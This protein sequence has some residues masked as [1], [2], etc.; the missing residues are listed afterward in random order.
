VD[1]YAIAIAPS[2]HLTDPRP[3]NVGSST[4][5][6]LGVSKSVEGCVPLPNVDREVAAVHDIE[7]GE[8]LLKSVQPSTLQGRTQAR[9]VVKLGARSALATLWYVNEA[10]GELVV[11]FHR[12]VHSGKAYALQQAQ[13][14]W[15]PT[16]VTRIPLIGRRSC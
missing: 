13:R 9:A 11:D 14:A 10:A 15:L 1:R 4:A 5:P 3:L 2:L 16:R 7:G 6:V 8:E 12:G